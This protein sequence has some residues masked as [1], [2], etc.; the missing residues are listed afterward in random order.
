MYFL[1]ANLS[2]FD[3]CLSSVAAPKVIADF[4]RKHKTISFWVCMAQ[5]FFIHFFGDGEM[6][7]LIAMA[8]DRYVA[9]CKPLHY[10]TIMNPRALIVFLILSWTVGFIHTTS[11]MIFTVGLPFCGP[12][13]VD[14]IFCDLP[15]VI[16]LACTEIYS[17]ELLVIANSGLLSLICFLLL[18]MSYAVMLVTIWKH[19]SSASS[20]ALSTLSAHITVVTIFFGPTTVIYAF[21]FNIYDV[22]KFLSIFYFI[23]APLLNPFIYTLR[24]QEMKAAIKRLIRD[25][26]L[27]CGLVNIMSHMVFMITLAFCGPNVV[28]D[29]FCD[30]P[31]ILKLVCMETFVLELLVIADIILVTVRHQSSG[32][33]SKA[34]STLSAHIT[35][36]TL[37]LEHVSS[38]ILTIQLLFSDNILSIFYSITTPLLNPIYTLRNQEMKEAMSR[39]RTQYI[40]LFVTFSFI[41]GATV[42]GNI[43]IMVTV[44]FSST[45]HSPM[46]FLLGNLSFLDMCL[47]TVTTPKMITDLLAV[48]KTISLWGCMAQMFFMHLFG[49]AEMP[50]LV[51]MAFDR[52]VAI[53]KPLHYR[54]IMNNRL[55]NGFVIISWIIGFIHTMSQMVLTVNLP[56]CDNN[57]IDNIFCDL[58]LV[59]KLACIETY[60]L[61][62]FV[63]ADSGLL[64]FLSFILLLISY[65]VILV[66]VGRRSSGGLSKALST[67][68]AHITVV[69]LFFGPCIFIYAWPFNSFSS[70]KILCV[71]YTVITPLL[72]PIVYTLRNEKMQ[73]AMKKLWFRDKRSVLN[74]DVMDVKTVKFICKKT[75]LG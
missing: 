5:L 4:L 27:V 8:I 21:P 74:D 13:I 39:L 40:F 15:L 28:N 52:Y 58:P 22:D 47:S 9:I 60:T 1:L 31:L 71:F 33:L 44:T 34:L 17:L 49:G 32:G 24:N 57:V 11:Q 65:T 18:L 48:H 20:K 37:S 45:L 73:G 16:K 75:I 56:F 54:S 43:L 61:E 62:L 36:V 69:T 66:T 3:L 7:L 6:S 64:S 38:L 14:N 67:L 41:Y 68:S 42:F 23:I 63:I 29:I 72:N 2:F 55:L 51:T 25:A 53:C 50:L 26:V 10:K 35:V 12:N 30:L 46:Y 19:S 59:I 70:N